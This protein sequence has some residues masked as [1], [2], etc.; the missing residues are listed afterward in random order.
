MDIVAQA[1]VDGSFE[2]AN[3]DMDFSVEGNGPEFG[4]LDGDLDLIVDEVMDVDGVQADVDTG[5]NVVTTATSA[6]P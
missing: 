5:V 1:D 4:V 2:V 3:A 6:T